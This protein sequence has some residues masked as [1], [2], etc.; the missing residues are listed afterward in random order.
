LSPSP[1]RRV[2][3]PVWKPGD[4]TMTIGEMA[5]RLRP[6]APDLKATTIRLRHWTTQMMLL[7]VEKLHEGTGK[8]RLYA[9]DD[10]YSAAYLHTLTELGLN[11]STVRNLIDRHTIDSV[12]LVRFAVPK[13]RK[14]N[15]PLYMVISRSLARTEVEVVRVE[16]KLATEDLTL[17]ID[18][19][20]LF[21]RI[22]ADAG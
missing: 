22:K 14:T 13:W 21:S 2:G 12:T 19:A 11:T 17:I 4:P 10:L 6:I 5:E 7:P 9:A 8:H 16:P 18:L 20:R 1:S 15:G 3:G